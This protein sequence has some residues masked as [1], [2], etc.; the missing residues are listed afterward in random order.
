PRAP[1]SPPPVAERRPVS[2]AHHGVTLTADYAWL[3][4]G[5]WRD[6][7][8]DPSLLDADIRAYLEAENAYTEAALAPTE[9]LQAALFT[10]MKGRL[11]PGD[12]SVPAPA[13]PFDYYSNFAA[14]GQYPRLWRRP[15]G[16]G[17]EHVLLDGNAEAEGKPYW[18]L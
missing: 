18:D 7:M 13:G 2:A 12:F 10:E 9:A 5:N 4:A 8:R 6:V 1:L 15:R 14:G 16:G 3:R 11:K 17:D